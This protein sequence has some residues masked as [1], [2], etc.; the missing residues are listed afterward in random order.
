MLFRP[1]ARGRLIHF[2]DPAPP[3]IHRQD[4]PIDLDPFCLEDPLDL[5]GDGIKVFGGEG[6]D[7]RSGAGEADAE[8]AGVGLVC[9]GGEDFGEAGDLRISESSLWSRKYKL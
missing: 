3:L 4:L 2:L 6:E 8:E 7:G 1:L 9:Q 5:R